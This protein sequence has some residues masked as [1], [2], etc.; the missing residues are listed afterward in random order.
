MGA[1]LPVGGGIGTLILA[2]VIYFM[3]GNPA[4][5]LNQNPGASGAGGPVSQQAPAGDTEGQFVSTVLASTEDVWGDI[6]RRRGKQYRQPKLRLFTDRVQSAC[7]LASSASGPFYCPN[8]ERVYIDLGFF[9]QLKTQFGAPGDFAQAYVIAHE[10][11]HHVQ[12][13]LGTMDKVQSLQNR[14]GKSQSNALSVKLEL[15]ADFYAGVWAHYAQKQGLL[16][17]GDVEEALTAA[18]AVGDDRLQQESQGYVVPDSFTHGT[19]QQRARWFARGLQ[20]GDIT[21]GDTSQSP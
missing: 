20:S 15:Q 12:N 5:V 7:G 8:D 10:V 13:L 19:S 6:F 14:V 3:G 11:G 1:A 17:A 18:S 16:E 4:V 2:V 9:R 21:Q